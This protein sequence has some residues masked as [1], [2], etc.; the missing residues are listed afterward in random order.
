MLI[1]VGLCLAFFDFEHIGESFIHPG[2][3]AAH[4]DVKFR[5]LV[6][7]PHAGEVILGTVKSCDLVK[8]VEIS[9]EFFDG[10][11]IPPAKLPAP[12][13]LCAPVPAAPL[14]PPVPV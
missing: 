3:G 11:V 4:V 1:G 8:G 10:V 14:D 2:D 6:F 9:L 12:A 13:R 7:R 5:V